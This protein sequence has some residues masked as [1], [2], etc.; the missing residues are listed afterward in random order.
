[1]VDFLSPNDSQD[2]GLH[3]G[4]KLCIAIF[5]RSLEELIPVARPGSK[6]SDSVKMCHYKFF[7]GTKLCFVTLVLEKKTIKFIGG[8]H[9]AAGSAEGARPRPPYTH[10]LPTRTKQ[11]QPS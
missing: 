5:S 6:I 7:G 9:P 4:I 10:T 1:M 8:P 3:P 2:T 11:N